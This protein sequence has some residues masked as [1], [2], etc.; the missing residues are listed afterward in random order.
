MKVSYRVPGVSG[1]YTLIYDETASTGT[2]A[3]DGSTEAA[4]MP[5][6]KPKFQSEVQKDPLFRSKAQ[7][8]AARG[9]VS[10]TASLSFSSVYATRQAALASI[11]MFKVALL[12]QVLHLK[13]E[14]DSEVQYYPN[15]LFSSY[16]GDPK[17]V[18]VVHSFGFESDDLTLTAP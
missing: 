2:A 4:R 18:S 6:F 13:I 14:Q 11:R 7:F 15:A 3:V 10:V 12:D 8:R 1:S 17:G 16:E 9:N 5:E